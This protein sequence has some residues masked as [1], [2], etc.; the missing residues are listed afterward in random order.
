MPHAVCWKADPRLIWTMV[1]TNTVTFVSY[2]IICLTL[3]YLVRHTRKVIARDW[4]LFAFGFALFI[5]ACGTTHL[6]EVI[7]TWLPAFWIDATANIVTAILS[8]CVCV[9]LIRRARLIGFSI[10]DYAA[11]L[12]DTEKENDRMHRSLLDARKLED[13]SR[14]STV[15]A[16]EIN[17]PLEAIQ[18]ILYIIQTSDKVDA[19]TV[20][21]ARTASIEAENVRTIA[22]STLS[23]FR[24]SS[25][26]ELTDFRAAA[27]SVRFV[28]RSVLDSQI[29][30]VDIL[31][32]GNVSVEALSGEVRQV[33]LNLTRNAC[34]ASQSREAHVTLT[35]TG[36]DDGVEAVVADQGSGIPPSV[37]AQLFEF[38][39]STK[40]E[41]GNGM[42]LWSVKHIITKHGGTIDVKSTVGRGTEFTVWWPR[43][44]RQPGEASEPVAEPNAAPRLHDQTV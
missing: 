25:K 10:N 7:T 13:W 22:K 36:K 6:M 39:A 26:P 27:E 14:M 3:I 28:L 42:G 2:L 35:F 41:K 17:N 15:V 43:R 23:F 24:Q 30:H 31:T 19:E 8:A 21:L 18:N 9:M 40:G 32:D 33:L 4:A 37:L 38:G 34:E 1:I 5:V 20:E 44:M 16:H 29:A 11:R 12:A